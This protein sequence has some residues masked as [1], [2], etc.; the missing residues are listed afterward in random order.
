ME[1]RVS[2]GSVEGRIGIPRGYRNPTGRPIESNNLNPWGLS[3]TE[4]TTKEPT[5]A[6]PSLQ[7]HI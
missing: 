6:G 5:W 4:T 7:V 1:F 3:D 2:Y